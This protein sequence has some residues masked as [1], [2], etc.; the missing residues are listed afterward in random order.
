MPYYM[1]H[2]C[3]VH[4]KNK[5]TGD[6]F[7]CLW[8][9]L[10]TTVNILP[11]QVGNPVS[12]S[13]P[14]SGKA[15]VLLPAAGCVSPRNPHPKHQRH[16]T[17]AENEDRGVAC[18]ARIGTAGGSFVELLPLNRIFRCALDAEGTPPLGGEVQMVPLSL[19]PSLSHTSHQGLGSAPGAL[20]VFHKCLS[21]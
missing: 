9:P 3:L 12:H 8:V 20:L 13:P 10:G 15:C 5:S 17:S 7:A 18:A 4:Q 11:H 14:T 19:L 2:F 6:R 1:F 16:E 21:N